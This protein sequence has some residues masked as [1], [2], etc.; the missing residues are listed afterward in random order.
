[1]Q[2]QV[3]KLQQQMGSIHTPIK[4]YT[5]HDIFPYPFDRNIPM[6]PFTPHFDVPK[7]DKYLGKGYPKE[8][9]REFFNACIE[10]AHEDSYLMCLFRHSLQGQAMKWFSQLPPRIRSWGD[11]A[12]KFIQ[13]FYKIKYE[14]LVT[15]LCTTKQYKGESFSTFLLR[16][17]SLASRFSCHIPQKKLVEMFTQNLNREIGYEICKLCLTIFQEEVDKGLSVEKVFLK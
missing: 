4:N 10:V 17:R 16:W 3:K 14:V 13:H 5:L 6:P 12:E 7:F 2:Q 15:N 9:I 1:M 8:H 11:L